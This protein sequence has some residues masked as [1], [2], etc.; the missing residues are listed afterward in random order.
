[1]TLLLENLEIKA[2]IGV[3]VDERKEPQNIRIDGAFTYHFDGHYL[4]YIAI[5]E[6]IVNHLVSE[7]FLL[8]EEALISLHKELKESFDELTHISIT[9]RKL[10]IL[11]DCLVGA[12]LQREYAS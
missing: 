5:K 10:D 2:I 12:T 7:R 3:L 6:L 8:L 9:L 4:D 11:Q 1:M